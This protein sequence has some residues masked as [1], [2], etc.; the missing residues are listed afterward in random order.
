MDSWFIGGPLGEALCMLRPFLLSVSAAVSIQS[1]VQIAV[2]DRFGAVVFPFRSSLT[3]SKRSPFFILATWI[4][5]MVVFSPYL[6]AFKLVEYQ[7]QLFC[8]SQWNEAL[9]EPSSERNFVLAKN[10]VS[11]HMPFACHTLLH[12]PYQAQLTDSSRQAINQR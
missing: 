5:A 11:S 4:V 7:G 1:L 9:G 6:F 12:H 3:S 10:V 8:W 2:A